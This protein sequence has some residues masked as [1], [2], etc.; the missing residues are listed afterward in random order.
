RAAKVAP[1]TISAAAR[2]RINANH[3][4]MPT[5]RPLPSLPARVG[6][7]RAV[8]AMPTA[9]RAGTALAAS[10]APPSNFTIPA[11]S[12]SAVYVAFGD[13]TGNHFANVRVS[14][15]TDWLTAANVIGK[16]LVDT[17]GDIEGNGHLL[18]S[19]SMFVTGTG[20]VEPEAVELLSALSDSGFF[21]PDT[22]LFSA[23]ASQTMP[24]FAVGECPG[25]LS[26]EVAYENVIVKS[27]A[28]GIVA[29]DGFQVDVFGSMF[30]VN[31]GQLRIGVPDSVGC[32]GCDSDE[33]FV[34]GALETHGNGTL[35]MTD[36]QPF[37]AVSDSAYFAGGS[38][39]GLLTQ[40]ES[41]FFGN[42]RQAGSAS[43][44]AA[45]SPHVAFF[46][47]GAT[48]AVTFANPSYAN[49][50]FGDLLLNDTVT[51][52]NSSVFD[53]G[54]LETSGFTG[55]IVRAGVAGVGM[56][57]KGADVSLI[58][59]DGVTWD[60]QDGYS[61]FGMNTVAFDNQSPTATQFSIER[62]NSIPIAATFTS[63][64]FSTRPTT[65]LYV[66]VTQTDGGS[67][68]PLTVAFNGVDLGGNFGFIAT[69]GGANV[70]GWPLGGG[71]ELSNWSG[72]GNLTSDFAHNDG[73]SPNGTGMFSREWFRPVT[74]PRA[75]RF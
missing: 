22:T 34:G 66:Q 33:L 29:N 38:T 14:G 50:H 64:S 11:G 16:M 31:S 12:D 6:I 45:T 8:V 41:D 18:I 42:F 40:G 59:F 24:S 65:G 36:N 10:P 43:A 68:G 21:S 47:S 48:Q 67:L 4:P 17:T 70:T 52:L 26:C 13:T 63:W 75:L 2:A 56:T 51:V 35:R 46:E 72:A 37:I 30:I 58:D 53:D 23:P 54:A 7:S 74:P 71:D 49:S 57:S 69:S 5:L 3:A 19:D 9:P 39:A 61:V 25:P 62:G 27:P 60:L 20:V 73:T 1:V 28:L 44:F 15:Q 32:F 55:E